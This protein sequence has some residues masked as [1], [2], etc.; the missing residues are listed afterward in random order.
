[1]TKTRISGWG[2]ISCAGRNAADSIAN[3]MNPAYQCGPFRASES[4][5][6]TLNV[7]V[8]E[9]PGIPETEPGRRSHY[10]AVFAVEEAIQCA[11]L[12]A[13]QLQ[14]EETG[15]I[16]G[17]TIASQLND[18]PLYASIRAGEEASVDSLKRY[19]EAS[20]AEWIRN[21]FHLHGPQITLSNACASGSDILGLADMWIKTG[22][23]RR[24]IAVGADGMNRVPIAG[25]FSLGVASDKACRPFDRDRSG[26]NLGEG[27]GALILETEEAARERGK[28]C[29]F[30]LAGY[31]NACDAFH[32]TRPHPEGKG[33][34]TAILHAMEQAGVTAS[35]ISFINAHGTATPANDFCEG[36][37]F[38]RIFGEN[39]KYLSTKGWTGHTLGAAG[40]LECVFTILMLEQKKIPASRGFANTDPEIPIS[41][42][43]CETALGDDVRYALST[44]L[45]FGG[46][47]A[48]VVVEK[49]KR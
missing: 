40:A 20:P 18:L 48:A 33:L 27:A 21:R 10:L 37:L 26:L 12:T 31:G 6:T 8:F 44:S 39:V 38:P 5:G 23:C 45:A 46:S 28:E 13:E 30:A 9:I 17:T 4:I 29:S 43:S 15:V 3:L 22:Q 16:F 42:V 14:Q 41:P 19:M 32:I 25:F 49:L 35:D 11:G 34:H 1:M 36:N 24:V 2:A 7:P 47:N